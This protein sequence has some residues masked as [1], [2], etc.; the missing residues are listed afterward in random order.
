MNIQPFNRGDIVECLVGNIMHTTQHGKTT[1]KELCP[2]NVGKKA[3]IEYSYND[4]YGGGNINSYCI[5]YLDTFETEAWKQTNELK[6]VERNRVDLFNIIEKAQK[7]ISNRNIDLKYIISN[8]NN[9][10][11]AISSD[12]IL[13]LFSKIGYNSNFLIHGEFSILFAEYNS[14]YRLLNALFTENTIKKV[15]KK[16]YLKD[17]KVIPIINFFNEIQIIKKSL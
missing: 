16:K 17:E 15:V 6:L 5:T 8:W 12:T 1:S 4:K 9:I 11:D 2:E 7:E 3:I 14:C 10:K 13:F